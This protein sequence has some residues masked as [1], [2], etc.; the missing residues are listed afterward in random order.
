MKALL[1]TTLFSLATLSLAAQSTS[2]TMK[3]QVK[4]ISGAQATMVI[5]S[6][7]TNPINNIIV[8]AAPNT[9]VIVSSRSFK[10]TN[11]VFNNKSVAN[12]E[13][14]LTSDPSSGIHTISINQKINDSDQNSV[15]PDEIFATVISYQ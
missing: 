15:S 2:A 5:D 11:G 4:V 14:R 13:H 7:E 8:S 9:E 12:K 3:V 1:F 6:S 10:G